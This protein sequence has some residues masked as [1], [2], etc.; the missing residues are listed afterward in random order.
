MSNSK[1]IHWKEAKIILRYLHGTIGYGLIYISTEDFR[2][3]GYTDSYWAGCMDDRKSTSG[4]SFNMGST[5][6]AWSTK[7]KPIVSLSTTEEKYKAV[8]KTTCE[9]VWLR[10][11]LEDLREQQ[12]KPIQFICDNQ[13]V[14]QMTKNTVI[15][16]KTKHIDIQYHFV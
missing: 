5:T 15:H 14:I 9:V 11:I 4:Y 13:S 7:K 6:I 10:R 16:K 2:L 8:A 1:E 12:E 3:I